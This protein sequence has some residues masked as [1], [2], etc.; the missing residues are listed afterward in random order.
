MSKDFLISRSYAA[1]S[2]SGRVVDDTPVVMRIT[3]IAPCAVT[4]V[5][6]TTS[7]GIILI[8]ADGTTT[9]TFAASTTIG[10]VADAINGTS[11]WRCKVLDA[12]RADAS[13]EVLIP[14]SAITASVVDGELVYDVLS[15]TD[16]LDKVAYR[17]TYD[18]GIHT[19]KS[20]G[21]HRIKL[22]KITY[23]WNVAAAAANGIRVYKW[24]PT[25]KT[26]TQI[27]GAVS[28]D[29]AGSTANDTTHTFTSGLSGGDGND[30]IVVINSGA[31]TDGATTNFLQCEYTK[32]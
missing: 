18:R 9:I 8:D 32:E 10:A 15:D 3:H 16:A 27:W 2:T 19:I 29:G 24:N 13:D 28:V 12:L 25:L 31:I 22:N 7:T 21:N 20:I 6:L 30:L 14:N 23:N 17:C 5:T 26:E 1:E 4:S 11:N